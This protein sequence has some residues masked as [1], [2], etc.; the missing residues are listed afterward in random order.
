MSN[1]FCFFYRQ[2]DAV[3]I[4]ILFNHLEGQR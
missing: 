1:L 2:N 3:V 4:V